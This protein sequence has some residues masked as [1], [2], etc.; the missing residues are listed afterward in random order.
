MWFHGLCLSSPIVAGPSVG[1]GAAG[2]FGKILV[3]QGF[4]ML[5]DVAGDD[6]PGPDGLLFSCQARDT[7]NECTFRY[8]RTKPSA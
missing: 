7:E 2:I 1:R 6:A 4:K 5:L 8:R 3:S